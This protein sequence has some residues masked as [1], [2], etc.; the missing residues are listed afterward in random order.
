MSTLVIG[1]SSR[2]VI[3][4]SLNTMSVV[5]EVLASS[6][7]N[8]V[9]HVASLAPIAMKSDFGSTVLPIKLSIIQELRLRN[10]NGLRVI[11]YTFPLYMSILVQN[12]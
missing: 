1:T 6:P 2:P 11:P 7:F 5:K 3:G 10:R 8:V 9:Q 12:G 4:V